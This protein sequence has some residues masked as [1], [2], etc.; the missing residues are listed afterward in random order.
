[1]DGSKVAEAVALAESQAGNTIQYSLIKFIRI[2]RQLGVRVSSA[3]AIDA[4]QA[5]TRVDMVNREQFRAA[6]R[7][8]LVKTKPERNVFELAFDQ[9]F[10]EPEEK[11]RRRELRRKQEEERQDQLSRAESELMEV[12]GD[13]QEGDTQLTPEQLKTFSSMPRAEQERMKD[14]LE[15]MKANPVNN[16]GELIARVMQSSLNYWRYHMLKA[17]SARGGISRELEAQLTGE[18][19]LDEIIEGVQAE[20]YRKPEDDILYKDMQSI[21]DQDLVKVTALIQRISSRLATGLSRRFRRSSRRQQIDIRRTMRQNIKYGGTPL[22]LRYRSRRPFRPELLLICDVSASM[23]RYARFVLQF[24]YG[25]SSAVRGIESFIFSENMERVTPY[26]NRGRGF[27]DTMTDIVN[28]SKQWGKSTNLHAALGTFID[29]YSDLISSDRILLVVSDTRTLSPAGAAN[30]LQDIK[31]RLGKIIW[32]NT[33]PGK[34]WGAYPTVAL[35]E[36]HFPM[37]E[38]N[39]IAHLEKVLHWQVFKNA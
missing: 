4:F 12:L 20:F 38:C 9:F 2:L 10:V 25:L 3:E 11:Q 15:R 32:L 33:L 21:E 13:W 37:Y 24:I 19:E 39:T 1:M 31:K 14:I 16:P 6:L 36:K 27:A 7:S 34:D 28:N 35:F 8:C 17:E 22:E 26:F 30:L 18:E 23:A 5:L 29:N